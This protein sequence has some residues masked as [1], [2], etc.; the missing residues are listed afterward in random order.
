MA[1]SNCPKHDYRFHYRVTAVCAFGR[2]DVNREAGK[3]KSDDFGDNEFRKQLF[4]YTLKVIETLPAEDREVL[5]LTEVDGL[6]RE[7]LAEELGISLTAAKS[8]VH[9]ARAKLRKAVEKCCRLVTDPYGRVMDWRK[10]TLGSRV[11]KGPAT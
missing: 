11:R 4:S 5:T 1:L 7:E 6:S 3:S 9:R 10:R 8:R 2:F